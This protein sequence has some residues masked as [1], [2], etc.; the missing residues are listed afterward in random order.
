[1]GG[2]GP[3][4]TPARLPQTDNKEAID[5][6]LAWENR[7]QRQES[8]KPGWRAEGHGIPHCK[9]AFVLTPG[10]AAR[11]RTQTEGGGSLTA[12]R[13]YIELHFSP[14]CKGQTARPLQL[15]A[16]ALFKVFIV[17]WLFSL[18]VPQT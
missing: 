16:A 13:L 15:I 6:E 11:S 10:H 18:H 14:A 8:S 2:D 3:H 7:P 17:P 4:V 5:S 12:Q 1:M 9:A